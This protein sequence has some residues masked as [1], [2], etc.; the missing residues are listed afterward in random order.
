VVCEALSPAPIS[1]TGDTDVARNPLRNHTLNVGTNTK[2]TT[3]TTY[4]Q[5]ELLELVG[6]LFRLSSKEIEHKLKTVQQRDDIA[7]RRWFWELLQNAKDAV[8]KTE[9]VSVVLEILKDEGEKPIIKFSHNGNP[10]RYQDAKNLIFPYSDKGEDDEESDK[11]GR[12]GTGFLA[13]HI[14]SKKII[15]RGVFQKKD[16]AYDFSFTLDRA[17]E[18]KTEIGEGIKRTWQEFSENR[19][20]KP[21]YQYSQSE[22]ETSFQ[23]P[24]DNEDFEATIES[25]SNFQLSLPFTLAFTP[26]IKTV[27]IKNSISNEII[28]YRTNTE[29]SS[30]V[31]DGITKCVIEK[32]VL[33]GGQ[34]TSTEQQILICSDTSVSIA[35]ELETNNGKKQIKELPEHHPVLFYPF[36]LIGADDFPFPLIVFSENFKPKEER[37][38]IWL[39]SKGDGKI[40]QGLF[41][42]TIDLYKSLVQYA[43]EQDWK[44][45]HLLFK[46]LKDTPSIHDLD[47]DWYQEMIQAPIKEFILNEPLVDNPVNGRIP[48]INEKKKV[49]F[50]TNTE[51]EIREQ[52]WD[53]LNTII[54]HLIPYKE[55]IHNWHQV[56]WDECPKVT[57]RKLAKFISKK[58]TVCELSNLFQKDEN[59]TL[60]W[61]DG[62]VS[63]IAKE[64]ESLL[65]DSE[66]CI[67]PNQVGEFKKKDELY[68]DDDTIHEELKEIHALMGNFKNGITDWRLELLDK[69][70]YL[71]LPQNK[72][73]NIADI[74]ILIVDNV[75]ELLRKDDPSP[76]LQ[77][78]FSK[79]W[80]WLTENPN[81]KKEY[82][83]GLNTATLNYKTANEKQHK[84]LS[85]LL[86]KDR[87]GDLSLDILEN[88][89]EDKIALLNDPDLELKIQLGEQA[90]EET[91]KE[92][93]EFEFKKKTGYLFEKLFQQII[94]ADNRFEIHKVEGEEDFIITKT[95]NSEQF[96]I[97][98]KSI[99]P[100]EQQVQMTHKQAKKAHRFPSNY[101][102]C[103]I[104][105]NGSTIDENYFKSNARFD[106]K[107]GV[108]LTDKVNK[109]LTFEASENGVSVEFEDALLQQYKKYRY[110]FLINLEQLE[111]E[112]IETFKGRLLNKE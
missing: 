49:R 45:T 88:L 34:T 85:E 61:L 28:E 57:L 37:D 93:E 29:K 101:F 72:T 23:Y 10:F 64:Q 5:D 66:T 24:I 25:I 18:N 103:F 67:L 108:K 40:N 104:P 68:L 15:V 2:M 91:R 33:N 36:P 12:F 98:L 58:E 96:Y 65:N 107:I 48:I 14:L 82:F 76:E 87:E 77:D 30:Q 31:K 71:E 4:N 16:N 78:L 53:L 38:G 111:Q 106:G 74:S 20:K 110:K 81:E 105:N 1:V 84:Q 3:D 92:E 44:N 47:E 89:T 59:A 109:A 7:R 52:M 13:T 99:R 27:Q 51:P 41:E 35:L 22:F 73:R 9:T 39:T 86:K 6:D 102:L 100:D 60:Q 8:R 46:T 11:S 43:S 19:T 75:K 94:N 21:N 95:S 56:L 54:P 50:P 112:T 80:I 70:I 62:V 26:K 55:D 32:T 63:L 97:E 90:L 83:K 17:G 79:L 42:K 69:R